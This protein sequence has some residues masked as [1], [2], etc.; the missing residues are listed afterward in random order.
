MRFL[1]RDQIVIWA[2]GCLLGVAIPALVS[3]EFVRGMRLEGNEVAAATALGIVNK[4]GIRAFW[5][6]TLLCGFIVLVTSQVTQAD[7]ILRRWTDVIWTGS[8]RVQHLDGNK[9]KYVYYGFLLAYA[10]W[11]LFVLTWLRDQPLLLVKVTGVLMN[12]ALGFSALQTLAVNLI[13]LP[14]P[15]RPGWF[16]RG[17][18]LACGLFF[19]AISLLGLNK[20]LID[21]GILSAAA[22]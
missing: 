3:L 19:I 9:V 7:G 12:F 11:G 13:L 8:S 16:L 15:L 4:T 10:I 17:G 1:R 22:G 6:L 18:L 5:F 20:A 21:L 2:V 14:R